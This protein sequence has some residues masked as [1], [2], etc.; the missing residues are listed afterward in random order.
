MAD[1][2][3]LQTLVAILQ[4]VTIILLAGG[5]FAIF[6]M[7][8]R[9]NKL[10]TSMQVQ[11]TELEGHVILDDERNNRILEELRRLG[12]RRAGDYGGES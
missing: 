3:A 2:Q 9:I 12:K 7:S 4:G 11:K 6:R 1:G 10:D 5:V 8:E